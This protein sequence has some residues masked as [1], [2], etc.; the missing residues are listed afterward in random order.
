M[1]EGQNRCTIGA[2]ST[3]VAADMESLLN[4]LSGELA[5]LMTS[6]QNWQ[7]VLHG[8]RAGDVRIEVKRTGV[9]LPGRNHAPLQPVQ[10]NVGTLAG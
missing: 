1:T 10:E 3:S 7:V 4:H 5:S 2:V 9:V 6:G 8:G